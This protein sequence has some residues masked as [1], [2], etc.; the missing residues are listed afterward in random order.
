MRSILPVL[1]EGKMEILAYRAR[2]GF[3]GKAF[4]GLCF[5]HPGTEDLLWRQNA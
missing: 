2:F 3:F 1:R 5:D 4:L